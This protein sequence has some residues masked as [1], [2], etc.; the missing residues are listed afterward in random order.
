MSCVA[1]STDCCTVGF[2]LQHDQQRHALLSVALFKAF[3][4]NI[5]FTNRYF[6]NNC[7]SIYG[8][9]YIIQG[10]V[11]G[12]GTLSTFDFFLAFSIILPG[13]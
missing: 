2:H 9:K 4:E 1:C 13:S 8:R 6:S 5:S 11:V 3:N 10:K 7:T 12:I